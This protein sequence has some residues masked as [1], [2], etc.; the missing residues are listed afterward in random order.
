M[1]KTFQNRF[2]FEPDPQRGVFLDDWMHSELQ[3][4]LVHISER[5]APVDQSIGERLGATISHLQNGGRLM[6]EAFGAYYELVEEVTSGRLEDAAKSIALIG[7]S[8]APSSGSPWQVF[9]VGMPGSEGIDTAFKR[10]MGPNERPIF[11]PVPQSQAEEFQEL[12]EDGL[13]LLEKGMPEI[14]A[15]IRAIIRTVL[16]AQAP[17]GSDIEFDGASHYELWGLVLLN[18]KF[19]NSRLAVA[20]VL[21]HECGHSLLF[22]MMGRELL[23]H[24]P[25]EDRF[26][27][28]L[29]P[30]PRPMD[31]IYHA[32]FVSARMALAM[33]GLA[34]SGLLSEDERKAALEAAERDRANFASGD[35]VVRSDGDLTETGKQIIEHARHWMTL[36]PVA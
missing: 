36:A 28:P 1:T 9:T 24:N 35:S 3:D 34:A 26:P 33:E 8:F 32:T 19:H 13:A 15:E 20:E 4:S 31:G 16:L 2:N 30:D 22:G 7:S 18:P 29:R 11:G 6:P 14:H 25:Y 12:L 27:S 5:C 23:V 17:D 10:R 21:A